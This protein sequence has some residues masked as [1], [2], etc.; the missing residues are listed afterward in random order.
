MV[1]ATA[2]N[3]GGKTNGYTVP[4]PNAQTEVIKE[5]LRK[6]QIHPEEISYMEATPSPGTYPSPP[7]PKL[8][9]LPSV[10]INLL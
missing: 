10:D 4:N 7:S 8:L 1:K 5:A 6:A 3:H 9:H 2:L